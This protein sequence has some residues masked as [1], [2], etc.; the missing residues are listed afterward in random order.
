MKHESL[1]TGANVCARVLLWQGRL[2]R[3][4]R[5]PLT[6]ALSLSKGLPG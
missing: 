1:L 4:G 5:R 6:F 3:A 2:P